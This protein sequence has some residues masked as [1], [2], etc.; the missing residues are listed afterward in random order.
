MTKKTVI[1]TDMILFLMDFS[2]EYTSYKPMKE[3][4]N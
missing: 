2:H 1:D 3:F 4:I